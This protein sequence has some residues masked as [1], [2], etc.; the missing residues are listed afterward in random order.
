[1]RKLLIIPFL[2]LLPILSYANESLYVLDMGKQMVQACSA[3]KETV[4]S[5]AKAILASDIGQL[6]LNNNE[7]KASLLF[8]D[9][10]KN[11]RIDNIESNKKRNKIIS[12][13]VNTTKPTV[14][15]DLL[16]LLNNNIAG[17]V[18]NKPDNLIIYTSN[19]TYQLTDLLTDV[20]MVPD[21]V[22]TTEIKLFS[23][24]PLLPDS[25]SPAENIKISFYSCRE[26]DGWKLYLQMLEKEVA[27]YVSEFTG[28]PLNLLT[29]A[30]R[31]NHD[32][33][34]GSFE[35]YQLQAEV[36]ENYRLDPPMKVEVNTVNDLVK[37]I[38]Q[39]QLNKGRVTEDGDE[40]RSRGGEAVE[41]EESYVQ[42]VFYATNRTESTETDL[43]YSGQRDLSGSPV[44]YG[45]C[46]VSIPKNHKKGVIEKPLMG[47]KFFQD[48]KKH[49]YISSVEKLVPTEFFEKI[50]THLSDSDSSDDMREDIVIFIHGFNVKFKNAVIR[51]AQLAY[52]TGFEGVP[53]LF[54]WPSDGELFEYMSD[55]EDATWSVQHVEDFLTDIVDKTDAKRIHI[56]AHSMGH[57]A[58]IGAL[59]QMALKRGEETAPVFGN[60]IFAAPDYDAE[61]FKH[62]IA[63]NV[64]TLAENWTLYTSEKDAALNISTTFNSIKRLG[65]P[66]T[67]VADMTVVD[68]SDIEVTPWSVPEF[69]SYYATKQNVIDDIIKT[70]RGIKPENR[71][72][73]A[74]KQSQYKYW[75]ILQ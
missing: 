49:V 75:Q 7:Q 63:P 43:I 57:Q 9:D 33:G 72:L 2:Y 37:Y 23:S 52:D 68:A 36:V 73:K 14:L 35:A 70:L 20:K 10:L 53:M 8:F 32:L 34:L 60:I 64:V 18:L 28:Y 50:N 67:N 41:P 44:K 45:V 46:N 5:S 38:S 13:A 31:F 4:L 51:T 54:S 56:V 3:S 21:G 29:G 40:I 58:L 62:Q 30:S 42:T 25:F 1:M 47:L 19:T 27:G 17:Q 39:S 66:V 24:E 71:K 65:L 55:R 26:Q 59:N 15:A 11:T 22:G 16:Q 69:H 61:L 12:K 6:S 74:M 48:P